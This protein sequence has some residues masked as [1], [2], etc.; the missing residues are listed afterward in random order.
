MIQILTHDGRFHADDVI[1]CELLS[2]LEDGNVEIIRTRDLINK[3][4]CKWIVDVGEE[5]IPTYGRF[6]HHQESC[7]ETWPGCP[8]LLSSSGLVFLNLW[9][10]ILEKLGHPD[11]TFEEADMI[12]KTVFLPIDAHDN[13]QLVSELNYAFKFTC[14]YKGYGEGITIGRVIADMNNDDVNDEKQNLRFAD[15]MKYSFDSLIPVISTMMKKFRRDKHMIESLKE[16]QFTNGILELNKGDFINKWVLDKID[17]NNKLYF[18]VYEKKEGEWGFSAV[19]DSKFVNRINLVKE[20]VTKYP[21]LIFI[22]K[23]LFCGSSKSKEEAI[24]ICL[25]SIKQHKKLKLQKYSLGGILGVIGAGI[26]YNY[27]S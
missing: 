17:P 20:D 25:D 13:G 22:H 6:D 7:K 8:V 21:N 24:Q 9:K 5:Y 27:F 11:A 1:A 26:L 16:R 19:Q 12:Y 18:T 14:G 15:A 10:K 3:H 4:Q 2:I 23:K